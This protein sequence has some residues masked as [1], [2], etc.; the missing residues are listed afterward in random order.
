MNQLGNIDWSRV[1]DKLRP[2]L[3]PSHPGRHRNLIIAILIGFFLGPLGIGLYL[4]SLLDFGLSL[5]LA[6]LLIWVFGLD[7]GYSG[8]IAGT[9]WAALRVVHDKHG[10]QAPT[11]VPE[12]KEPLFDGLPSQA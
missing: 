4:R 5:M 10:P 1:L 3:N 9:L 7:P 6:V 2:Y 11:Q 12:S 8:T